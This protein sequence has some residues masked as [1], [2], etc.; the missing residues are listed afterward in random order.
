MIEI[1]NHRINIITVFGECDGDDLSDL[2][3]VLH[4]IVE[5]YYDEI[6]YT[7]DNEITN[8]ELNDTNK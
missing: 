1:L 2:I 4:P 7:L 5:D 8:I 3:D 6:Q